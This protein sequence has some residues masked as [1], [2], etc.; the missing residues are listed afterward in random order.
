MEIENKLGLHGVELMREEERISKK[1]AKLL[2]GGQLDQIEVG[3]YA[4][5]QE[6]HRFLFDEI[7]PFAG[8]TRKLNIAKGNF[9]FASALYLEEA[10]R[11]ISAMPMDTFEEIVAKYIE[12]NIA[13]PFLEGNG[14]SARIWLDAMLKTNIGKVVNWQQI[15]RDDYL[16]AMERSPAKDTEL[17]VLLQSALTDHY[18]DQDLFMHSIDASYQYEGYTHYQAKDL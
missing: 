11:Q 5:L 2:Y 16:A 15:D 4:G 10:L 13:H 12:M 7:Y 9:R 6:I 18:Q 17:R 3:T 14:R 1:K 8:E